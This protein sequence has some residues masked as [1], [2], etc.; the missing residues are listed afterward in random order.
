MTD[1]FYATGRLRA[2]EKNLI[3]QERLN[4]LMESKNAAECYG[5]LSELGL[6]GTNN[7]WETVLSERLQNAYAEIRSLCDSDAA[8]RI[9]L[10]PYDCNNVKAAIKGFLRTLD[11][12]SMMVDFGTVSADR[13]I[14]M[15]QRQN[16]D[17][18]SPAMRGA[19][20]SAMEEY[21][22]TKDPQVIDL[23]LDAA[24]YA[25]ML[26]FAKESRSTFALHL[27]QTKIDLINFLTAIRVLRMRG[28]EAGWLL[29][30]RALLNGGS[31]PVDRVLS[32]CQ[33][34]ESSLWDALRTTAYAR[35]ADAVARAGNDLT[36][37]EREADDFWMEC[38]QTAKTCSFG[39]EIPIAYLLAYEYEIRNLRIVITGKNASLPIDVIRKRIRRS[40][41]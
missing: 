19:A 3:G 39:V 37:I 23:L 14:E 20:P 10:F 38:I 33:K 22:K 27:V 18:L 41:V 12:H 24:C 25:D 40:Y 6:E 16:Y 32:A 36:T 9:W 17:L 35:F 5:R 30:Q 13:V 11:P 34:G 1:Y 7:D 4:W 21:A 26:S 31:L 8:L 15:V 28:G 29:L 2:L